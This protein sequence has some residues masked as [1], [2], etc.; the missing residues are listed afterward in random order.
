MSSSDIPGLPA[1]PP[2]L[3]VVPELIDPPLPPKPSFAVEG[4]FVTL[5]LIA[6]LIRT[7]V[8]ARLTKSWGWDDCETIMTST[9]ASLTRHVIQDTCFIA[10]VRSF[11]DLNLRLKYMENL[12]TS[13]DRLGGSDCCLCCL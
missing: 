3:G 9:G 2:S 11:V 4:V 6:V 7:F 12:M 1:A 5:M 10:V 13:I 8:C